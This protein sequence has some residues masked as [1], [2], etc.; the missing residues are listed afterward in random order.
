VTFQTDDQVVRAALGADQELREALHAHDVAAADRLYAPEFMLNGP[1]M[2]VQTRQE[3][4]DLLANKAITQVG[5]Q[6]SIEAAY[7]SGTDVVVIMGY[8][9]FVWQG[10]GSDLDGRP[11]ARRFTNVW[12]LVDGRWQDIARQATTVPVR[13]ST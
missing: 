6:R 3:T 13:E 7:R 11:T 4:L 5:V 10:T 9:S 1:A 12:R 2:R 8:E